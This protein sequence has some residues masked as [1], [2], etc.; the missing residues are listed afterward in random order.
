MARSSH[1]LWAYV[2]P[3]QGQFALGVILLLL[4]SFTS[5]AIPYALGDLVDAGLSQRSAWS[6]NKLLVFL[7]G[8]L[9][10]Q[11]IISFFRVGIFVRV[12]ESVVR[13]IRQAL[14]QK[15]LHLPLASLQQHRSGEL[16]SRLSSDSTQVQE[17]M[18]FTLSE[19]LRS[20]VNLLVGV[21]LLFFLSAKLT[22]VMLSVIPP[23]SLAVYLVGKYIRRRSRQVQDALAE[24]SAVAE[25]SLTHMVQVKSYTRESLMYQKYQQALQVALRNALRVGW[26]R[27]GFATF[28]I[29]ALFGGIVLVMWVGVQEV[30]RGEMT[31][32]KL[33][34]FL[35]YTAFV[36]GAVGAMGEYL[37][38]IQKTLGATSRLQEWLS[39]PEENLG[40]PTS[41]RPLRGKITFARVTFSYPGRQSPVLRD[42][43]FTIEAGQKVGVV[44]LSGAG[45]ST[46]FLL[47]Q[48]FYQPQQ[49]T[50]YLDD[51]PLS[52]YELAFLRSQI[53]YVAQEVMLFSGSVYENIAYGNPQASEKAIRAAAQAAHAESFILE[54]PQGYDTPVGE[55]GIQ[56]SQGQRQRIALARAFL[57]NPQILLLDEVTSALDAQSEYYIQNALQR[58][59]E[60]RTT[61]IVAH[62]LTT[63]QHMDRIIV[64][65]GG[66][67]IEEGTHEELLSQGGMYSHLYRLM[68]VQV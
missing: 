1:F 55:R 19:L 50:I 14:M 18:V 60:G 44:G 65:H 54:L 53:G 10:L 38:Q 22:L 23:V 32:G 62:R 12:G 37:A 68:Q 31:F 57:K 27:G 6:A 26:L 41:H 43:S 36:G 39:A 63:L 34:S 47:L 3:Y 46:L 67:I 64:L 48:G 52:A 61:L 16:L 35:I 29:L 7:G 21:G 2:R 33:T 15:F 45:K 4:S 30:Q 25:E 17:G 59:M 40:S 5:L 58:L 13:D 8:I 20:I 9:I 24:A 66:E 56:L 49:G 11:G 42:L 28:I 51:E